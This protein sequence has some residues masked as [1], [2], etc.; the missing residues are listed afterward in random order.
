[1]NMMGKFIPAS[2]WTMER[3]EILT[4]MWADGHS[5]HDIAGALGEWCNRNKVIGKARRLG[6]RQHANAR[7]QSL[8]AK[9][10]R[11]REKKPAQRRKP[12][13]KPAVARK[14]VTPAQPAP[15]PSGAFVGPGL[16][17]QY[18]GHNHCRF[19]EGEPTA[20]ALYCGAPVKPGASYCT[21]HHARCWSPYRRRAA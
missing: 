1:M 13:P 3:I 14:P 21:E 17:V 15:E 4:R 18:L 19:I 9:L 6:L 11:K 5:A 10:Q 12:S 8:V 16:P 20:D 2:G 7:N